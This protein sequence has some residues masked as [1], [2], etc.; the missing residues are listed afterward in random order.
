VNEGPLAPSRPLDAILLA[1]NGTPNLAAY[2]SGAVGCVGLGDYVASQ[3]V[4]VVC[5]GHASDMT[6]L[7]EG[8]LAEGARQIDAQIESIDFKAIHFQRGTARAYT[9]PRITP[10]R[11]VLQG[12]K[13]TVTVD[14]GN[15]PEPANATF[16]ADPETT[17]TF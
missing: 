9:D 6:D 2:L 10:P 12:G 11:T 4:G 13:W 17:T 5:V 7:C 1:A 14:F 15:G 3:C 8:G 16:T